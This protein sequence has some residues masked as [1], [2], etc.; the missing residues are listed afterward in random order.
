MRTL[1]NEK[2][3]RWA[4]DM[5]SYR[6]FGDYQLTT[7]QCHA[8]DTLVELAKYHLTHKEDDKE[9]TST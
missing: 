1:P 6:Y 7:E 3:I 5:I 4:L 2:E 9:T 8:V